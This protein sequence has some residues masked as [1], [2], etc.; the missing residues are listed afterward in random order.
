MAKV[1]WLRTD[2]LFLKL[3]DYYLPR[4]EPGPN[5]NFNF[6]RFKDTHGTET[7][8]IDVVIV[9][10]GCGSG[11][12]AKVLAATGHTVLV[13]DKG[14]HQP[15]HQL[16]VAPEELGHL[17]KGFGS[18]TTSVD[19][20]IQITAGKCWGGGGTINWSASLQTQEYVEWAACGLS[21][22]S[23]TELQ[24]CLDRVCDLMNVRTEPIQHNHANR[25]LLE[26]AKTLGW[27]AKN[28]PQN[29]SVEH[30]CGSDCCGGCRV[31]QCAGFQ[32]QHG[33]VKR[34][35]YK[36]LTFPRSCSKKDV[37]SKGRLV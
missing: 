32:L 15:P 29:T 34:D 36:D 13:A 8:E 18:G 9:G 5:V 19:G 30:R 17:W 1:A 2:P 3:N 35:L 22:F 6:I 20:L 16:P 7:I 31:P 14:Y 25:V 24:D 37:V 4:A 11:V 33:P 27:R 12:C 10:S 21:F 28:I 26:G 23:S